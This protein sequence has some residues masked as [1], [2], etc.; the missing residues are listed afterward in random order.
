M[1][2]SFCGAVAGACSALL[3][4]AAYTFRR[5]DFAAGIRPLTET[6]TCAAPLIAAGLGVALAFRVGMFNI[7]GRGQML[8]ASAAAG[9]IAF[10]I[11]L[12][13]GVHMIV[14]LVAGLA[15]GAVWAGVV[16]VLKARTG[17][18][19]WIVMTLLNYVVFYLISSISRSSGLRPDAGEP[20]ESSVRRE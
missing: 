7:G 11:D 15:A 2:A 12:P 17:A 10:A 5:P 16:G 1:L 6:L 4:G 14:A 20:G 9:W 3:Q 13:W 19:A 8:V 18:P